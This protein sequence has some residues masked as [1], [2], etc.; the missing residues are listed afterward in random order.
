MRVGVRMWA[1]GRGAAQVRQGRAAPSGGGASAPVTG[2]CPCRA[3]IHSSAAVPPTC[4][5]SANTSSAFCTTRQPYICRLSCS[6]WPD[7]AR[8]ILSRCSVVPVGATGEGPGPGAGRGGAGRC[9]G[10]ITMDK[11]TKRP[12]R[13]AS[14]ERGWAGRIL[15]PSRGLPRLCRRDRLGPQRALSRPPPPPL[16]PPPPGPMPQ[17]FGPRPPGLPATAR[18]PSCCCCCCSCLLTVLQQLLHHVVAEDVGAQAQAARQHLPE[19]RVNLLDAGRLP[20]EG[21]R[22]GSERGYKEDQREGRE[23]GQACGCC[24]LGCVRMARP[25][26]MVC[27]QLPRHPVY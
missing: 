18:P 16:G 5:S 25:C 15:R 11:Y 24:P 19:G 22:G 23:L 10:C 27:L 14:H 13:V 2:S 4:C 7:S 20:R 12:P 3:P 21:E 17:P 9:A 6:T 8:D 26:W 1:K